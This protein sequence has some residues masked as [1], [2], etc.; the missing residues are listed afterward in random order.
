MKEQKPLRVF[1]LSYRPKCR[2]FRKCS[3]VHAGMRDLAAANT[4]GSSLQQE[5]SIGPGGGIGKE[6]SERFWSR[7]TALT[8]IACRRPGQ[9]AVLVA[10]RPKRTIC[11]AWI[12]W[13]RHSGNGGTPA[14]LA[15]LGARQD[16]TDATVDT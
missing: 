5:S 6:G 7:V 14:S 8:W 12:G 2:F 16:R 4:T 10:A 15:C 9:T 3:G 11:Q 13:R 1:P